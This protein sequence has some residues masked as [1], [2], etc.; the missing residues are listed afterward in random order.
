MKPRQTL[1]QFI[2][3]PLLGMVLSQAGN[4]AKRVKGKASAKAKPNIPIVGASKEPVVPTSTS[5][6]PIMGPVQEKLTRLNVKAMRKMLSRPV[7]LLDLRSTALVQLLGNVISKPPRKLAP[8]TRSMRKKK[9]LKIAFVLSAFSALAPN[10]SVT[11]RPN[12]T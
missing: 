4:M 2:Q 5:R 8:K 9:M 6:K 10:M 11:K 7:V 3:L 12:R 1:M